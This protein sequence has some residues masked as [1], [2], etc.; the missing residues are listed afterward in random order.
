M[1]FAEAVR[2]CFNKYATFSGRARRSEY[3][4]FYL[5]YI[6]VSIVLEIIVVAARNA[7][8]LV[9]LLALVLPSL[10]AIVRRLHDTGR[11]GWWFWIGLVPFIG[12]IILIVFA[13]QDSQ[14]GTNQYGPSPKELG[15]A[16]GYYANPQGA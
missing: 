3:W 11:S 8:P 16:S 4:W 2:T 7:I 5:F 9:L 1:G 14:P 13:C 15:G 6:L 10:A 12:A